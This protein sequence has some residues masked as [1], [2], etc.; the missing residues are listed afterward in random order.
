MAILGKPEGC[1][2]TPAARILIA[3]GP[4]VRASKADGRRAHRSQVLPMV[5]RVIFWPRS[6][7]ISRRLPKSNGDSWHD[8]ER[9]AGC[10]G[11][12]WRHRDRRGRRG[13]A[14]GGWLDGGGLRPP[15]GCAGPGGR[16]NP[17][18]RRHGRGDRA[19]RQ[20]EGRG[21]E[22]RRSNPRKARP[23]RSSG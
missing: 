6:C 23:D 20:Q 3:A 19:R 18:K 8:K 5:L 9:K 1:N 15:Q 21:A 7:I 11:D 22:G 14:G 16:E 2:I 13:S 12:G 4:L 10:L 17:Q